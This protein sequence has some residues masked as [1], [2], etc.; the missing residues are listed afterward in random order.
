[1]PVNEEEMIYLPT[2][3]VHFTFWLSIHLYS[4]T[5]YKALGV[6]WGVN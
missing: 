5:F 1:M 3:W 4:I 6:G 2:L